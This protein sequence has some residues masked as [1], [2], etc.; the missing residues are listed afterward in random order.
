MQVHF[1]S[2][3]LI[4]WGGDTKTDLKSKPT[5]MQDD[6]LYLLNLGMSMCCNCDID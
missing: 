1:V 3:V 6:A 4:V 5:D 2:S